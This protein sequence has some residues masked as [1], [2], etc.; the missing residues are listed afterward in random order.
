MGQKKAKYGKK[1]EK[2]EYMRGMEGNERRFGEKK[3]NLG[4]K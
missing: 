3:G 2:W 4:Q 1:R